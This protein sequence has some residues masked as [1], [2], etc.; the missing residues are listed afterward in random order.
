MNFLRKRFEGS[1]A[2]A[3]VV[4]FVIFVALTSLQGLFGE[5]S[6]YW[7]YA[8]KTAV[9]AWRIW[10]MR[11]FVGG[12]RWTLRCE[13]VAVGVD[14]CACWVGLDGMYARGDKTDGGWKP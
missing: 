8:L 4:P 10:G 3:R 12:M 14:V 5:D 7:I 6:C 13:A 11:P 1:P 9:G 2:Y